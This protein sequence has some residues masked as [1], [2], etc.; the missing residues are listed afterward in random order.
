M[1]ESNFPRQSYTTKLNSSVKTKT[2]ITL[3]DNIIIKETTSSIL[4]SKFNL[5][6]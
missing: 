4:A 5:I 3:T 2:P 6:K 1:T